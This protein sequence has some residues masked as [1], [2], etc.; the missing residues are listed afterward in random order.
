M[1]SVTHDPYEVP[2][3]FAEPA[4]EPLARYQQA[5]FYTDKFLSALD[6]ELTKL[7]LTDKTIFCVIADHGEAFGE[8]G[9]LGHERIAFDENLRIPFCLRAPF[10]IQPKTTITCPVSSVD[11]APTLLSLLGFDTG[12]VGFDGANVLGP[13]SDD[14]KVYFSG[15]LSQSPA[16]FVKANRK[17]IYYPASK[18]VPSK[19][20]GTVSVYDL[21]TDPLE[22]SPTELPEQQEREIA[23]DIVTWRED[24]I[25]LLDQKRLG[26]KTLFDTWLCRWNN[27][28][29]SVKH[30]PRSQAK[31]PLP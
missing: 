25:F 16:G 11:L 2:Q 12:G 15:W 19:V 3:W 17:F 5:I 10:L 29:A 4:K 28:V 24:T 14:R 21:S 30:R 26:K 20:E 13:I 1:L 18:L 31:P 8:H 9:L 6:V 7:N 22:L 27:R 23:D